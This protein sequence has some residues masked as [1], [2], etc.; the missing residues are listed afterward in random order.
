MD[1]KFEVLDEV[2]RQYRR[3]N[4]QGTL[5]NCVCYPLLIKVPRIQLLTMSH[6]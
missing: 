6:V 5:L 1:G 2:T 4:A 3:F